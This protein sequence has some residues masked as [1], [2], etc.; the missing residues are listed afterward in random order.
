MYEI[1]WKPLHLLTFLSTQQSTLET[2]GLDKSAGVVSVTSSRTRPI[3]F[4]DTDPGMK[5]WRAWIDKY[6]PEGDRKDGAKVY[7]Y[8]IS[9]T[10]VQVLLQCGNVLARENIMRQAANLH[11]IELPLL[12]LGIR[13]DT[14]PTDYRPVKQERPYRFNGRNW[15]LFGDLISGERCRTVG[16]RHLRS[17]FSPRARSG[18]RVGPLE[19][20]WM[21][22]TRPGMT[23]RGPASSLHRFLGR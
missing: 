21:P 8:L 1:N 16:P 2:A 6:Y 12:L 19:S 22:G 13:I 20:T 15:E 5:E 23:A 14:S 18:P 3:Q 11:D 17:A 7:A 9:Q 10:L 4:W